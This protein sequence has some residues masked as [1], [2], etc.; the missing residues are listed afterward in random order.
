MAAGAAEET[1]ARAILGMRLTRECDYAFVV[2]VFLAGQERTRAISCD[3]IA[4]LLSI[5]FDF[6]AKILQRL[7]RAGLIG[8]KQVIC[9][10]LS[11]Y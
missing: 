4:S 9:R 6:L 7:A 5:P 11:S 10:C 3:E 2:L 8:S 1:F